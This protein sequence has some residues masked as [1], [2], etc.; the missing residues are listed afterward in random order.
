MQPDNYAGVLSCNTNHNLALTL[1]LT[2]TVTLI[3][4]VTENEYNIDNIK[5]VVAQLVE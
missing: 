3:H 5:K 1:N 2:A 4:S